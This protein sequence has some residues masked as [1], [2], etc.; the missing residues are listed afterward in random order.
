MDE[1]KKIIDRTN[2]FYLDMSRKVLTE[3]EYKVIY[4]MLVSKKT[5]L[6]L[7]NEYYLS[8]ERIR[9]IYIDA[10]NKVKSITEL[11]QEIDHYKQLRDK[12]RSDY[13]NGNV[14]LQLL[15]DAE[16]EA[17]LK[18]KLIDSVF[19]FSR[20]LWNMLVSLDIHTIGDMVAVPLQEYQN[21]RG[22][23]TA[24]KKELKAFIEFENIE[25]LINGYRHWSKNV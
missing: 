7:A 19:P 13:R 22:F 12:L 17:L 1:E 3:R 14:E 16:K 6:E 20:R 9:Q 2:I 21:F 23:K 11:F 8:R 24:C 4:Q 15:N 10:Y 25:E 5:I 18:K